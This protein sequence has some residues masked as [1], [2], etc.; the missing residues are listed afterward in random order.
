MENHLEW[1]D[2]VYDLA[3]WLL[4]T[5]AKKHGH[6]DR[7]AID[8]A[9]QEKKQKRVKLAQPV[10][11]A[12]I[13][14]DAWASADGVVHYRPDVYN[15]DGAGGRQFQDQHAPAD[16]QISGLSCPARGAYSAH[17]VIFASRFTERP[18]YRPL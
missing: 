15:I 13:Y 2:G 7:A 12:W 3:A 17:R 16:G 4:S 11:V 6:W 8:E 5:K 1:V 18:K 14:L 10:P 9:V